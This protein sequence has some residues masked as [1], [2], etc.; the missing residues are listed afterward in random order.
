MVFI[1]ILFPAFGH[2][3]ENSDDRAYE[4]P[5]WLSQV[6]HIATSHH[7]IL[8]FTRLSPFLQAVFQPC[9]DTQ[10]KVSMLSK[11]CGAETNLART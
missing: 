6:S 3:Y 5:E 9:P 4:A 1:P 2:T 8:D 10:T 7:C 11:A